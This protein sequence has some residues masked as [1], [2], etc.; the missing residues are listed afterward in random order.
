MTQWGKFKFLLFNRRHLVR[1]IKQV[2]ATRTKFIDKRY[3]LATINIFLG[4]TCKTRK[5]N[6]MD[7]INSFSC[8]S[9]NCY[10]VRSRKN[11]CSAKY[12]FK[13]SETKKGLKGSTVE[14]I[15]IPLLVKHSPVKQK[16]KSKKRMLVSIKEINCQEN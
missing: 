8:W 1:R 11:F 15:V 16:I 5:N 13:L 9:M 14:S 3:Y 7:S 10:T 4:C 12:I 2:P 6:N